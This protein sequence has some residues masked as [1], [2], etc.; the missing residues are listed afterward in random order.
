MNKDTRERFTLRIPTTLY[1][2]IQ[3]NANKTGTSIN[4]LILQ[5]LWKWMREQ[6]K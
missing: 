1:L 6:E 5:V 4:A 2:Q 3:D